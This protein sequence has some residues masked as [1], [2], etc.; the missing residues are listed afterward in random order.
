VTTQ[1][2][3]ED[4]SYAASVSIHDGMLQPRQQQQTPLNAS[5]RRLI[6]DTFHDP[7]GWVVKTSSPY[8]DSSTAPD[9]TLVIAFRDGKRRARSSPATP[10]TRRAA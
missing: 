5:A 3:R 4:G 8:Y 10:M 1:S 7:P 6:N 2:L 9:S